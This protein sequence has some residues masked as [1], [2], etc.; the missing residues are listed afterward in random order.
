MSDFE[1][2]TS[3]KPIKPVKVLSAEERQLLPT[4]K[5][6]SLTLLRGIAFCIL[7]PVRLLI[8]LFTHM[9]TRSTLIADDDLQRDYDEKMEEN[10]HF[11][12]YYDHTS[13]DYIGPPHRGYSENPSEQFK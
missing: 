13:S 8:G 5:R 4:A 12:F 2:W 7:A 6:W 1:T 9:N 11:H 3:A 10:L